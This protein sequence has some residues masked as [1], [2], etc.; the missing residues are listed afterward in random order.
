MVWHPQKINRGREE[1]KETRG[2]LVNEEQRDVKRRLSG[3][4]KGFLALI[5]NWISYSKLLSPFS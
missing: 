1:E 3:K 5:G 2:A 4:G